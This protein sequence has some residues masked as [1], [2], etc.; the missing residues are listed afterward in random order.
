MFHLLHYISLLLLK[1]SVNS[2]CYG[3]AVLF[4]FVFKQWKEK[5]KKKIRVPCSRQHGCS[6]LFFLS[7]SR[8]IQA[9][10]AI[11]QQGWEHRGREG[12]TSPF[13]PCISLFRTC[14]CISHTPSLATLSL[15]PAAGSM[16]S[17]TLSSLPPLPAS[18]LLFSFLLFPRPWLLEDQHSGYIGL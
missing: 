7:S 4:C 3:H 13:S 6:H 5:K 15:I 2:F 10:K 11:Q 16:T 1:F 17:T 14:Q 18:I 9:Q 8:S 12:V